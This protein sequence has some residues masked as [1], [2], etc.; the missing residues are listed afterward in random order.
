MT[1]IE[2]ACRFVVGSD[3]EKEALY[4]ARRAIRHRLLQQPRGAATA[5]PGGHYADGEDLGFIGRGAQ[6]DKAARQ[7]VTGLDEQA[8]EAAWR[9]K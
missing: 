5:T 1:F 3:I 9:C 6:Q 4:T 2:Q 8:A 7:I